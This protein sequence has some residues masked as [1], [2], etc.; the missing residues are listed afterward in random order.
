MDSTLLVAARSGDTASFDAL[1]A[2]FRRE[3]TA[4]C[5]RLTGSLSDAD[6]L[7]QESLLRAWKGLGGYEGKASLRA[8]LYRIATNTCLTEIERRPRRAMPADHGPPSD[9]MARPGEAILDPIWLDPCPDALWM[10]AAPSPDVRISAR[11]SVAIAFIAAIQTLPPLQRA[12]LIF[13]DVLGWSAVEVAE[14]LDTTVAAV[15]SALQRARETLERRREGTH[16][17]LSPL[18]G[19]LQTLLVRYVQAWE[20]GDIDTLASL[21]REDATLSMPP[22]PAWYAGRAVIDQFLRGLVPMLGRL[23]L[24]PVGISGGPGLAFYRQNP[25]EDVFRAF[26]LQALR[27]DAEGRIASIDTFT[28]PQCFAA[29]GL[30]ATLG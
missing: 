8:W 10:T 23:R 30:A 17:L 18:D 6:D 5:Y 26:G 14:N 15:N 3:L 25:G 4:H 11:E 13:R 12:V 22:L 24:V 21:L 28:G 29:F 2:P 1:V 27:V 9:P 19:P 7:L 16:D 20:S